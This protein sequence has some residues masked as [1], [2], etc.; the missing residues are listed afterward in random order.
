MA[1]KKAQRGKSLAELAA[2]PTWSETSD[3]RKGE[4]APR[5]G[6][7]NPAGEF[8]DPTGVKLTLRRAKASARE[9]QRAVDDG[10]LVVAE[11]CGCG[12]GPGGCTPVWL[13]SHEVRALQGGPGPRF[14]GKYGSPTWLELWSNDEREVVFAHGDV[15]WGGRAIG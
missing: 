3:A 13:D 1:K 11:A 9:A 14:T 2:E 6:G 8:F 4:H 12:G 10:A 15:S 7:V 5:P